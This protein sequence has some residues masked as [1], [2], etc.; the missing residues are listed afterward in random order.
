MAVITRD[1]VY[2]LLKIMTPGANPKDFVRGKL[3]AKYP[4]LANEMVRR[5]GESRPLLDYI[6]DDLDS[7]G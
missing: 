2:Q 4:E 7:Y 1:E 5:G 6:L 3:L